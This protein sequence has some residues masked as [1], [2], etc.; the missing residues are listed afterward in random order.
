MFKQGSIQ[1]HLS[2]KD[3]LFA[4]DF[5]LL[6]CIIS[7]GLFSF[8]AMYSTDGGESAYHTK[9]HIVRFVVFFTLFF[10]QIL[11]GFNSIGTIPFT[12]FTEVHFINILSYPCNAFVC[13]F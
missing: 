8:F 1:S 11:N 9:S 2:V 4:M 3:K 10:I 6:G 13:K 12:V 7:L 5:I